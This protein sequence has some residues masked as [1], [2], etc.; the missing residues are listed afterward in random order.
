MK[1]RAW[2][3]I[4]VSIFLPGCATEALWKSEGSRNTYREKVSSVLVAK[5][6]TKLAVV[7]KE[8]HYFFDA[9][10][11]IVG[12]L[13]TIVQRHVEANFGT[14]VVDQF[15]NIKGGYTLYI[16]AKAPEEAKDAARKLEF[17]QGLD[18]LL[19]AEGY[20]TGMRYSAGD[21]VVD[22]QGYSLSKNYFITVSAPRW[23]GIADL[24]RKAVLTP[25]AVLADGVI[26]M[27]GA[28]LTMV[29]L[30]FAAADTLFCKVSRGC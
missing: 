10:P 16:S 6:G 15:N 2:I 18:G 23:G 29:A 26:V 12:T 17:A 7:C 9:P 27:Q 24:G 5:D 20:L 14:F 22:G 8:Y 28:A 11:V 13:S 3:A 19:H 30:P 25:L 21:V 4:C 1:P